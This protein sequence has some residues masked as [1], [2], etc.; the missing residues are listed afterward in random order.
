MADEKTVTEPS[1]DATG[2]E[3]KPTLDSLLED[4]DTTEKPKETKAEAPSA[5][6]LALL[7]REN[8][9]D[10]KH[11]VAPILKG[12]LE[13]DDDMALGYLYAKAE[14]NPSLKQLFDSR[15]ENP[16]KWQEALQAVATEFQEKMGP[17]E[18]STES[19][20]A[21]AAMSRE[22]PPADNSF[23]NV[24]WGSMT[25]TEFE[26][27]KRELLKAVANGQVR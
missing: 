7:E 21:A 26:V 24:D 22:A 6:V 3:D 8:K 19:I 20:A 12:D 27:R 5:D 14:S 9:R 2:G 11:E 18:T 17:K 13:I 4:W 1:A 25:N 10:L 23:E 16:E 15:Y